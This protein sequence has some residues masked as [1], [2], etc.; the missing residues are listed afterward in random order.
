MALD[1]SVLSELL[2]AFQSG[3]GLDL[4]RESVRL[5]CQE[6]I[7]TELSALIGAGRYER[8][9]D[10]TNERNG[11]KGT[12]IPNRSLQFGCDSKSLPGRRLAD[13]ERPSVPDIGG[14]FTPP[15]LATSAPEGLKFSSGTRSVR[16]LPNRVCLGC[17]RVVLVNK[18]AEHVVAS[19]LE[20]RGIGADSV[21][22]DRYLKLDS[23]MRALAVVVVGIFAQDSL[24][25]ATPKDK[26]PV[27]ALG[28]NRPDPAFCEGISPRRSDWRLDHSD[29][30]GAEHFVKS[31]GELCVPIA[32][33]KLDGAPSFGKIADQVAGYLGD[34]RAGRMVSNTEDVYFSRRQFGNEEHVELLQRHRVHGEEVRG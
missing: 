13:L 31:S 18:A 19:D 29:P 23:S 20:R 16:S 10:R 2:A 8:A 26:R 6:L 3:E 32:D 24:E 15:A 27:Q 25:V 9:E 12:S 17:H 4:I 7:E 5:V 14:V 11:L 33:E 1:Q 30:L 21:Y 22:W 28:A 34:E